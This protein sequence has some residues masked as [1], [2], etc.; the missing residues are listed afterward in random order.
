MVDWKSPSDQEGHELHG[1]KTVVR[2]D[3]LVGATKV[4]E[5][6]EPEEDR[7]SRSRRGKGITQKATVGRCP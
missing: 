4:S 6:D 3:G 5:A 7:G 1:K 2:A